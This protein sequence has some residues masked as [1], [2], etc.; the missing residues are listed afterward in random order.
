MKQVQLITPMVF[1]SYGIKGTMSVFAEG[2]T[3]GHAALD[4]APFKALIDDA[5]SKGIEIIPHT[6]TYNPDT[7]AGAENATFL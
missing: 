2:H 1:L 5:Y 7:R 6:L 3:S 4:N